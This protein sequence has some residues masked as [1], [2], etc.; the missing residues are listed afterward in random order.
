MMCGSYMLCNKTYYVTVGDISSLSVLN[1]D[2]K[3][4]ITIINR[5]KVP[6]ELL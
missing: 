2:S 4:V 3:V 1:T 5:V 6:E